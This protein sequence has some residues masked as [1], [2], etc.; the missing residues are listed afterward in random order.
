[1]KPLL[2]KPLSIGLIGLSLCCLAAITNAA[3]KPSTI[4]SWLYKRL[5]QTE[6]LIGK[7]AYTK[8]RESLK[9]IL[10]DV[11][12]DS[13]EQAITLRSLASVYALEDKYQKSAS[14]LEQVL[15]TNALK[16]EQHQAAL[17]NLGQLY[18]ATEQ[19][20][21]AIAQLSPW[22]KKHPTTQNT[23]VRVLLANAYS[24]LTQYRTALPYIQHV[25]KHA[26]DPKESWLQL[27]LALAYELHKYAD[28]ADILRLLV[29]KFPDKKEYWQQL[30]AIYQQ[31]EQYSN[32]LTIQHLAYTK[33]YD[34]SESEILQ[35]FNLFLYKKLPYQAAHI[36]EKELVRKGVK[37]TSEHW[38]L[39]ANA[40]TQAREYKNAINALEKAS[41]LHEK[42]ELYLQLGRIHIEQELWQPAIIAIKKALQ[43]GQ[44][45]Q[46][47]Q[48]HILLGI[49]YHETQQLKLAKESFINAQGYSK[50]KKSATQWLN[51]IQSNQTI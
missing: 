48:A 39:L 33:G 11:D 10:T 16:E 43:K 40:W 30:S 9:K 34:F 28:A 18:M 26:K 47:G 17:L 13:Y 49:G 12:K 31:L 5:G 25:I 14:I 6:Q 44:L 50:A 19:Y 3:D 35:L 23:Q 46:A 1:M 29:A 37:Q 2:S 4:P 21:K 36:L 41:A 51:Y 27:N 45:K 20:K 8:A 42:G 24:Q 32:A 22:L 15:A 7:Q 38:A